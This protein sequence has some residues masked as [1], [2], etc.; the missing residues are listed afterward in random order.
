MP[1]HF[2]RACSE[3]GADLLSCR[4]ACPL[5]FPAKPEAG[6]LSRLESGDS[7]PVDVLWA[8]APWLPLNRI[9]ERGFLA[10]FTAKGARDPFQ[11]IPGPKESL[12]IFPALLARESIERHFRFPFHCSGHWAPVTGGRILLKLKGLRD[13][14]RTLVRSRQGP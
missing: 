5:V 13:C 12:E 1:K 4:R 2:E 8:T 7:L 9:L 14:P 10:C 6:P 3:R 11:E